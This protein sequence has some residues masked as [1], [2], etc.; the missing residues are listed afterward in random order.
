MHKIASVLIA[1]LAAMTA[2][3]PPAAA[4]D[5]DAITACIAAKSKVDEDAHACIGLISDPCLKGHDGETTTGMVE[6]MDRESKVW[7]DLLN[8]DYQRLLKALPA[9]AADSVRQAQ[10]AWLALRD[11][12]CKVPYEIYEGGSMA[13]IDSASCVLAHTG[14]RVLQLRIWSRMARPEDE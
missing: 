12:D 8:A 11:A 5:A 6:C 14:E 4:D 9:A 2:Q 10:R 13:R 1:V 3:V 7:D